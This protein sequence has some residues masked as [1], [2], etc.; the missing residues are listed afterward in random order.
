MHSHVVIQ[1]AVLYKAVLCST[2]DVSLTFQGARCGLGTHTNRVP[3]RPV[4][5]ETAQE[6]T[7]NFGG[8][9]SIVTPTAPNRQQVV[10]REHPLE[11][12]VHLVDEKGVG[13]RGT[14][15]GRTA[16]VATATA[17]RALGTG[18]KGDETAQK[19]LAMFTNPKEH[20]D[21]LTSPRCLSVYRP[22]L[23]VH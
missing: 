15:M 8:E 11:P 19:M 1:L 13:A 23:S 14:H 18:K 21:Y 6:R 10:K 12:L 4:S 7:N 9:R 16:S 2:R 5:A 20:A 3:V 17:L 22:C